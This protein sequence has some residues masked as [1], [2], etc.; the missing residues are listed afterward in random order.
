MNLCYSN[1]VLT[2][3]VEFSSSV[4]GSEKHQKW[5]GRVCALE[6]LLNEHDDIIIMYFGINYLQPKGLT[7][8]FDWG[9]HV[10]RFSWEWFPKYLVR[11]VVGKVF[12]VEK[13][14]I[15]VQ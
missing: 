5:S 8:E 9:A 2:I 13:A 11:Y 14:V 1:Q 15:S 4:I 10:N 3:F 7:L 6:I 12:L